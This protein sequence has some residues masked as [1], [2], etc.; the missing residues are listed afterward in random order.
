VIDSSNVGG[1]QPV[2]HPFKLLDKRIPKG[3]KFLPK[4][5]H[6]K[7]V[8]ELLTLRNRVCP[9]HFNLLEAKDA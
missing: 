7:S 8:T 9:I 6:Y 1:Y 4:L 5:F 2:R 3:A